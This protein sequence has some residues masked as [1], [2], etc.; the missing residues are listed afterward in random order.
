PG[1]RWSDG[2][3]A[4]VSIGQGYVLASPL[5]M[6][7][8]TA[9]IANRGIAYE[10]HLV[11]RVLDRDGHDVRDPDT[12]HLVVSGSPKMHAD[13]HRA[14]IT[15]DQIEAV[16]EGMRLVVAEGTGRRAQIKGETIAGKTGTAQFWRGDVQDNHAWFIAFAPYAAPRYAL[17]V[18]VQGAK[19]G[20]S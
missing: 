3:T 13:L 15:D 5:Q 16:R 17:C 4:N 2:H 18:L 20:G 14:G 7:M 19:S 10:P 6:A 12:G 9:T 11:R 1:E 8:A